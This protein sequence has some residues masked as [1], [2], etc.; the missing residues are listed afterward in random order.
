MCGCRRVW[1][2]PH[3]ANTIMYRQGHQKGS[4]LLTLQVWTS[5]KGFAL[6]GV[7]ASCFAKIWGLKV[8][9]NDSHIFRTTQTVQ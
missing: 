7:G 1:E 2:D 3:F 9:I 4:F 6:F 5:Q 8:I